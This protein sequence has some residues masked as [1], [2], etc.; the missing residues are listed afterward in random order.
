MK[1]PTSEYNFLKF[2]NMMTEV[3]WRKEKIDRLMLAIIICSDLA[4]YLSVVL[5]TL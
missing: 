2:Q 4:N 5:V 3:S 1:V